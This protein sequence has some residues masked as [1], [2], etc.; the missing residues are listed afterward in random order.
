MSLSGGG[1]AECDEVDVV[2]GSQRASESGAP[3]GETSR[4]R[5]KG[6]RG[7]GN[8]RRR[9][10]PARRAVVIRRDPHAGERPKR[11]TSDDSAHRSSGSLRPGT[12]VYTD[13][14]TVDHRLS[15]RGSEPPPTAGQDRGE[16]PPAV[17]M[18]MASRRF[19]STPEVHIN[20]TPPPA[21]GHCRTPGCNPIAASH[22]S[23]PR[24]TGGSFQCRSCV[25]Y[26]RRT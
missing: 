21:S 10:D 17:R 16:C 4:R 25:R 3:R 19:T 7:H 23:N 20:S 6:A 15:E 8:P 1:V 18:G 13:K 12:R 11:L 9:N 14:Y 24:S 26:A 22:K 5:R 2:A